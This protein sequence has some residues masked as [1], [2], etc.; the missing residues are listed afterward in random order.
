M[1]DLIAGRLWR[2]EWHLSALSECATAGNF[3][4]PMWK[5]AFFDSQEPIVLSREGRTEPSLVVFWSVAVE[6]N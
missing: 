2:V 5:A 3:E 1:L 6:V 4:T